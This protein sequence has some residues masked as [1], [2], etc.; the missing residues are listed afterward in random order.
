ML[1]IK[2]AYIRYLYNLLVNFKKKNSTNNK[3]DHI[4]VI[5]KTLKENLL[6]LCVVLNSLIPWPK[7]GSAHTL[8]ST[9]SRRR[10][11]QLNRLVV[12]GY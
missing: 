10:V 8:Y 11:V 2:S 5:P 7:T 4:Y 6:R 9:T 1:N 3:K 12:R